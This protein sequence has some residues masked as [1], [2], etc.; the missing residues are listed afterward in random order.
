[1]SLR[2]ALSANYNYYLV[3]QE[4]IHFSTLLRGSAQTANDHGRQ[5]HQ[6]HQRH[7]S[8]QDET[9]RDQDLHDNKPYQEI[10][11]QNISPFNPSAD[12][13][14]NKYRLD[15]NFNIFVSTVLSCVSSHAYKTRTS[16]PELH[17]LSAQN[18]H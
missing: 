10:H 11:V 1:M 12:T 14:R 15:L 13:E 18:H 4:T 17:L 7:G 9:K 3:R 2:L 5:R 6:H 16:L 8:V